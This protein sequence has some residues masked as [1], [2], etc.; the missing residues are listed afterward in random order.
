MPMD[1]HAISH[2][3]DIALM[4]WG[5]FRHPDT[6]VRKSLRR[7]HDEWIDSCR[8]KYSREQIRKAFL[9]AKGTFLE[10]YR[11]PE[12]VMEEAISLAQAAFSE[13]YGAQRVYIANENPDHPT[14][15]L[16]LTAGL[17]HKCIERYAFGNFRSPPKTAW[18]LIPQRLPSA[19]GRVPGYQR[20]PR[21]YCGEDG[22]EIHFR[23]IGR[24]DTTYLF[25]RSLMR[26]SKF[27]GIDRSLSEQGL[28]VDEKVWESGRF[29]MKTETPESMIRFMGLIEERRELFLTAEEESEFSMA[30]RLCP[31]GEGHSF[32]HLP[33]Q[34]FTKGA[35]IPWIRIMPSA[36]QGKVPQV[37]SIDK[38]ALAKLFP[39]PLRW[40]DE[41]DPTPDDS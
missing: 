32:K 28:Y 20:S 10:P 26:H 39:C 22:F 37:R 7:T 41:I 35:G 14:N 16:L 12:G 13:A 17:G 2:S 34:V 25:S 9:S 8:P 27:M 21:L 24:T 5:A 33:T 4:I 29:I 23:W 31:M 15:G 6:N 3:D 40:R 19:T 11:F 1:D 30:I 36:E 18:C 38:A